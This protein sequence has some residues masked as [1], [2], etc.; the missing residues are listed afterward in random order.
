MTPFRTLAACLAL[1]TLAACGVEGDPQRPEP[2]QVPAS[3]TA[4]AR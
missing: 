2:R 3:A 4:P 1:A